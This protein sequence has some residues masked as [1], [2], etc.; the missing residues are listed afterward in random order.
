MGEAGNEGEKGEGRLGEKRG[1]GCEEV[2]V[3]R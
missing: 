3:E 1:V 2:G